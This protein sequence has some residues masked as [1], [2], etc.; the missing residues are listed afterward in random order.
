MAK[1]FHIAQGLRGCYMPD[2]VYCVMVKTR[3][4]LKEILSD[5][6]RDLPDA[7]YHFNRKHI[8]W[9]AAAVWREAHK[10][11]PSYYDFAIG[12]GNDH[13]GS[14]PYGILASVATRKDYLEHKESENA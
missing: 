2:N 14:R 8:A 5:E 4:E 12:Y 11:N 13:K 1:Y 3:R 7:G 10:R 6:C 9:A